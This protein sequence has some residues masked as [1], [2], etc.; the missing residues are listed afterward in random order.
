[1]DRP[2]SSDTADDGA[3]RRSDR[4]R[5]LTQ[6][7]KENALQDLKQ[8]FWKQY[9]KFALE[10]NEIEIHLSGSCDDDTLDTM[11]SDLQQG[12]KEI[13]AIYDG[14]KDMSD[15]TPD[16]DIRVG[17]DRAMADKD[18]LVNAIQLRTLGEDRDTHPSIVDRSKAASRHSH[19]D[20]S[21]R[22]S[23]ISDTSSKIR[24][25]KANAAARRVEM[26]AKQEECRREQELE[27]L[28][29][30]VNQKKREMEQ[31]RLNMLLR[32]EE[33]KL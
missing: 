10:L 19:S 23:E 31:H 21:S 5:P 15:A 7:A 3:V 20:M 25:T 17:I 33:T 29:T 9:G 1:M 11:H 22:L 12:Y 8:A 27:E 16:Q 24:D 14:I 4:R 28:Q 2:M 30:V 32:V 26:I 13:E 18:L 6:K